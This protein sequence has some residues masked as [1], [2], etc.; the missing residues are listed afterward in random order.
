MDEQER[1]LKVT[2]SMLEQYL[3]SLNAQGRREKTLQ[4]YR[5]HLMRMYRELPESKEISPGTLEEQRQKMV[6]DGFAVN[7][8]NTF[9][10][11][12]NGFLDYFGH[13][14]YQISRTLN[15]ELPLQPELTRNEYLRL[16][17]AARLLGKERLYL[18]IKAIAST[19]IMPSQLPSLTVEAVQSGKLYQPTATVHIPT[20]LRDER[21]DY[22]NR[23]GI[24][25]GSVFVTRNGQNLDR[26]NLNRE[27][28]ALA[29]DARVAPEKCSALCLRRL[30][31]TTQ[32]G[33]WANIEIL[34]EQAEDRLLEKEQRLIG[35]A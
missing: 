35:W 15:S 26:S 3:D 14:E 18:V 22:A 21:L 28:K 4:S 23:E 10:S 1:G 29:V 16:L 9:T 32:E 12:V 11:A 5:R 17:S 13:R 30:Y 19:G 2:E 8:I 20:V 34:V 33:L 6:N 31:Q 7:T 24:Y 25:S 27:L